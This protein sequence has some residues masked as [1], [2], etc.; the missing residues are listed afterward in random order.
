MVL[1]KKI[2]SQ[3]GLLFGVN[4]FNKFIGLIKIFL[5]GNFFGVNAITDMYFFIWSMTMFISEGTLGTLSKV[6]VPI[7][8][9]EGKQ[10]EQENFLNSML[11]FFLVISVFIVLL[12]Y[13][14]PS[15]IE[16]I[17]LMGIQIDENGFASKLIKLS[18]LNLIFISFIKVFKGYFNYKNDFLFM[19]LYPVIQNLIFIIYVGIFRK[20][21]TLIGLLMC[22]LFSSIM[23]SGIQLYRIRRDIKIKL[24]LSLNKNFKNAIKMSLPIFFGSAIS[25]INGILDKSIAT[26]L[27]SGDL[28]IL[29]YTNQIRM[30]IINIFAVTLATIIFSTAVSKAKKS[31]E[32]LEDYINSQNLILLI[33][34]TPLT[35]LMIVFSPIIIRIIFNF[36]KNNIDILTMTE[37]LRYYSIS[38][39]FY[40]FITIYNKYFYSLKDTLSPMIASTL[41]MVINIILNLFLSVHLGVKGIALATS[42]SSFVTLIIM[43]YFFRKNHKIKINFLKLRSQIT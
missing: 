27:N 8:G 11:T 2:K 25:R 32:E 20:N 39:I 41:G 24:R 33:M 22:S 40:S 15:I 35:L 16:P 13:C 23:S 14:F 17:F 10:E 18:I 19:E 4:I 31:K 3:N 28:S 29:Q 21:S 26:F 1:Y 12:Y 7:L 36:Q 34:I 6:I 42:I 30:A 37:T 43:I 5:I 38:I 9:H